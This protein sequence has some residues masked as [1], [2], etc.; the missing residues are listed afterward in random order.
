MTTIGGVIKDAWVFGIIPET[1][2]CEGW[3]LAQIQ[4]I[5]DKVCQEWDHHGHLVKHLP[6][7]MRQRHERIHTEAIRKARDAG[8]SP[9][10]MNE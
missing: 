3:N 2:T 6:E 5:M 10:L 1:E 7:E 9:E 8:W 4:M